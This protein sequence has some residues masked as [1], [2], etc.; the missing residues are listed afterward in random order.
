MSY[1]IYKKY[2]N[3]NLGNFSIYYIE[4][5]SRGGQRAGTGPIW[6]RCMKPIGLYEGPIPTIF[7]FDLGGFRVKRLLQF[8]GW[9]KTGWTSLKLGQRGLF[10]ITLIKFFLSI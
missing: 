5:V 10:Y 2:N 1:N 4:I 6:Q 7:G 8:T 9:V 3:T